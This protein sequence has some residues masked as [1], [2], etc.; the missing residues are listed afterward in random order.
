MVQ[1]CA[2]VTPA[3]ELSED[4]A[5]VGGSAQLEGSREEALGWGLHAILGCH[6]G[7]KEV[8]QLHLLQ[9]LPRGRPA[10]PLLL[11]Q[12]RL[13]SSCMCVCGCALG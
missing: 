3:G 11:S 1:L 8:P 2:A 10:T 13:L 5:F 12:T 7:L 6:L 9:G 4:D